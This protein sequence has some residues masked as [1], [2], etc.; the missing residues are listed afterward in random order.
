MKVLKPLIT[1]SLSLLL[2]GCTD[3]GLHGT[4]VGQKGSFLEKMT[5]VSS[6]KVEL[7]F[8]GST[9]EATYTKEDNKVKIDNAGENQIFTISDNGCLEGGGF[10]GTYC[11]E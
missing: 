10:I 7:T 1:I 8:F 3:D 4:Y 6:N 11:K 9:T 5:F 2:F